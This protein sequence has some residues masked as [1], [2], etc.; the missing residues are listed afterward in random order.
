MPQNDKIAAYWYRKATLNNYYL[1]AAKLAR[2]YEYGKGVRRDIKK[3]LELYQK[4][5]QLEPGGPEWVGQG[6][7]RLQAKLQ[8]ANEAE[9]T[10][11]SN[12]ILC[13]S[14]EDFHLAIIRAGG[15]L[16]QTS[17]NRL[18]DRYDSHKLLANSSEL[19]VAYTPEGEFALARY[20][21]PGYGDAHAVSQ[22]K[23]MIQNRYGLPDIVRGSPRRGR[24][25][26]YVWKLKDGIRVSVT[27]GWPDT[28][29]YMSFVNPAAYAKL[30]K[31]LP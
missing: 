5:R 2:M 14:R 30:S 20:K 1:A 31:Q 24:K 7:A 19:E 17:A 9:T 10:L 16:E 8:C 11:F 18:L 13:A 28:T 23:S 22:V 27:R 3:A 15:I 26:S 21:F 12:E 25:V 6:I 29:I 4:S